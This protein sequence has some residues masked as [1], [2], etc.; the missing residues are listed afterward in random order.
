MTDIN[1]LQDTDDIQVSM[2]CLIPSK[3]MVHIAII[4]FHYAVFVAYFPQ[5]YTSLQMCINLLG[6]CGNICD[7]NLLKMLFH[8]FESFLVQS[9]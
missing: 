7:I 5:T 4:P 6:F 8:K 2:Q 9:K 1:Q 3:S